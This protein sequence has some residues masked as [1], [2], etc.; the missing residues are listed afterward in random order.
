MPMDFEPQPI[1]PVHFSEALREQMRRHASAAYPEECCGML[2]GR[3]NSV[4]H[5]V[6]APNTADPANRRT[7]YAIDPREILRVDREART[8]NLEII[9]YYHSHPDHPAVP[10][11]TDRALAWEG[12]LYLIIPATAT[13][14]G[15]PR[16]W[17]L[18][19]TGEFSELPLT[20]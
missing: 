12:I 20:P 11:A 6:P 16:A 10:S 1:A 13:G 8:K 2:L 17:K 9:G 15:E 4:L 5:V 18:R 14:S 19:P 7:T 3:R